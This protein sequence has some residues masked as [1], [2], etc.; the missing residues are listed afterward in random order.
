MCS[1]SD[2][3]AFRYRLSRPARVMLGLL[4]AITT[5]LGAQYIFLDLTGRDPGSL[6]GMLFIMLALALVLVPVPAME[7]MWLVRGR[8][9]VDA[10]GLR[11]R[12]WGGWTERAWDEIL[13]VGV[14]APDSRREDDARIHVV[15]EDEYEFIHGFGLRGVED[16][17]DALRDCGALEEVEV[18]GRHM[19]LCRPGAA[20]SVRERAEGHVD[21]PIDDDT[22]DFW[23]RRFRRF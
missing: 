2:G 18:I 6:V 19:F 21:L 17:R 12:G 5:A 20:K 8:V 23:S 1:A 15:T 14:P 11:W 4:L 10:S 3:Q 9:V 16:L 13:A 7:I 22:I